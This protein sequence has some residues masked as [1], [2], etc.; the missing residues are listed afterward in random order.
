MPVG[1]TYPQAGLPH[2]AEWEQ[3]NFSWSSPRQ[4]SSG[5]QSQPCWAQSLIL[6]QPGPRQPEEAHSSLR[7]SDACPFFP[8][9]TWPFPASLATLILLYF[10]PDPL[11]M[12]HSISLSTSPIHSVGRDCCPY[13]PTVHMKTVFVVTLPG[14]CS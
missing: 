9:L 6:C 2:Q 3:A 11:P 1:S 5:D 14:D 8:G 12:V 7:A 13:V 10:P 4:L